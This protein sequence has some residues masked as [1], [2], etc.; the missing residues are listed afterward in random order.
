MVI[1]YAQHKIYFQNFHI[2]KNYDIIA[3][4]KRNIWFWLYFIIA[5][6]LAIYF[7]TRVVMTFMGYGPTATIRN[8]SASADTNDRDLNAVIAA[9]GIAPGTNSHSIPL[10]L[11]NARIVQIPYIKES[12]VRRLANGNLAIKANTY[13]SVAIWTDGVNYYPISSNG[14]KVESPSETRNS[15]SVVFRG[16]IPNEIGEITKAANNLIDDLDYLEWI[17][18]RRWNLT[19]LGGI[20]IMLPEEDP[21]AAIGNIVILNQ[22]YNL[23]SKALRVIDMRDDTRILVK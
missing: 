12:A 9:A 6:L 4:M 16:E 7:A 8:I 14:K 3:T 10:K 23:L 1:Y 5:I 17:D 22:K 18:N 20:T 13:R 2:K 19:T 21:I 11:V 15:G